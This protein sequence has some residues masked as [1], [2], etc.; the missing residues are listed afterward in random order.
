MSKNDMKDCMCTLFKNDLKDLVKTYRIPLDLHPAGA[1]GDLFSFS[2]H[3]NTED[4]CM[5]DGPSSLK[6][7]KDKFFLIDRRAIPDYLTWRHSCS[8]VS[9]DLPTDGYDRNDV[10]QLCSRLIRLCEMREEA[11]VIISI[12]CLLFRLVCIDRCFSFYAEMSIYDFMTLPSWS[13]AKIVEESHHLPLSLLE[14]V[15]SHT[16]TPATEG[17][18]IPLPTPDE[19]AASLPDSCLVKKSKGSSQASQPSKRRKLQKRASD[20][21]SSASEL[22]QAEGA[23]EANLADL[24][25]EIEDSLERDEGI[26]IRF[27]SA[28]TSCLGKRLGAP[29]IAVVSAS[30]PSH[31]GI[32]AP[33][34]TS[35]HSLSLGGDIASGRVGK[36]GPEVMRRQIDPLDYLAHSA[37]ARDIEYD[38]IP[39]DEFGTSTRGEEIDLTLFSLAP[40]PY[41][42]PY[43]YEGDPDMCMK[44][45]DRTITPAELRR[46]ESLLPLE[47]SNRVNVLSALLV[48]HGYEL[49]SFYTKLVSSKAL[50]QEKLNQK[51]WDVRELCSQRDVASED[52]LIRT[53]AKLSE[54]ALTVRDLQNKL[55][56]EKSKSQGYK[57]AIDGLREEADFDKALVDFPTTTFPFLSK[58]VAASRV[59]IIAEISLEGE[60]LCFS[61]HGRNICVSSFALLLLII[62]SEVTDS[63]LDVGIRIMLVRNI[64]HLAYWMPSWCHACN[65][66]V[67]SYWYLACCRP[68]HRSSGPS[69]PLQ[70]E[71]APCVHWMSIRTKIPYVVSILKIFECFDFRSSVF[72]AFPLQGFELLPYLA[73]LHVASRLFNFDYWLVLLLDCNA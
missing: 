34:S 15:S 21:G 25:A 26:S 14:R 20:A 70:D 56:L 10:E 43:P 58:I 66:H 50:L 59:A 68:M 71:T 44:A 8:C 1:I 41:H 3:R 11:G 30:E 48:S 24:C 38:Q 5:D 61:F 52:E 2:K 36:S 45:L 49:N 39:D 9:D 47:L 54:Q 16:T 27:V 63:I 67:Y 46:T 12:P 19:I 73:N 23:D 33:T 32:L 13:Y 62:S 51:K 17:A 60:T 55:A 40:G 31:V 28:L 42:M 53:D 37:L 65:D 22:D 7:W 72:H 18:I 57:D 29:S 64:R 6:K 69:D 4:V 35:G